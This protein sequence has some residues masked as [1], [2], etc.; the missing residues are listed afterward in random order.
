M[1][2]IYIDSFES[3]V[4]PGVYSAVGYLYGTNAARTGTWGSSNFSYPLA[5]SIFTVGVANNYLFNGY[6][7]ANI[8]F[9][10]TGTSTYGTGTGDKIVM[11]HEL[12]GGVI[13]DGRFFV[14][15]SRN[16]EAYIDYLT[17]VPVSIADKHW[18]YIEFQGVNAG[19]STTYELRCNDIVLGSGVFTFTNTQLA[20]GLDWTE[21][22]CP[23]QGGGA[24]TSRDD[25]YL[26]DGAFYG[27]MSV[28]VA[29]VTGS[30]ASDEWTPVPGTLANYQ[31]VDDS[32]PN[33]DTDYVYA[34]EGTV[35]TDLY[36]F[37][38][39]STF[40]GGN[41]YP[42]FELV[43][44]Y[45]TT[46]NTGDLVVC[47]V[48]SDGTTTATYT[49]TRLSV[50]GSYEYDQVVVETNPFTAAAWTIE[51]IEALQYGPRQVN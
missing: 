18:S 30:G 43:V 20:G 3:G 45:P 10:G 16:A 50:W 46:T 44:A 11:S 49:N 47:H 48:L 4:N 22:G 17:T 2:L 14:S 15:C 23:G 21:V 13:S 8:R 28:K 25:F 32:T 33:N 34:D 26:S 7:W 5:G 29:R 31:C 39:L 19:A 51:E 36:A 6:P 27:D 24:T 38:D 12:T 41:V 40:T 35:V 9:F 37:T 1:G 42:Q